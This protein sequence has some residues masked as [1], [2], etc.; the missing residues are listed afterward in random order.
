MDA[1]EIVNK[2]HEL[3]DAFSAVA[4]PRSNYQ[5]AKFVVGEHCTPERQYM[6]VV[7]ELQRKTTNIRR[8]LVEQR[9]LYKKL[10]AEID[11][12]K[13]ELL[14]IDLDELRF[15]IEGAVRE[16]NTL[17]AIYKSY[18]RYTAEQL[19]AA[20]AGYW[21]K[22]LAIQSQL[23]IEATGVIGQGNADALRM[24]GMTG[25]H[26]ERFQALVTAVPGATTKLLGK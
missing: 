7:N 5:I 26:A 19:Q 24:A 4:Q 12:D 1:L 8:A 23:D 14:Q 20:E 18:P 2:R 3:F 25:E 16:F 6:Q 22:R 15:S 13:Q 11:P 17:Y 9:I 21:H 10:N